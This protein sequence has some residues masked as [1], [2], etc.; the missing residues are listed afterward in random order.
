MSRLLNKKKCTVCKI[1][2]PLNDFHNRKVA[3]DGKRSDC[4]ECS[5][6]ASLKYNKTN[7]DKISANNKKWRVIHKTKLKFMRLKY[8]F[9]ITQEEYQ[10][11]LIKQNDSCAICQIPQKKLN[12]FLN[13]DHCHK[14]NKI[15][16]LL[17]EKC[18][19]GIGLFNDSIKLLT[20]TIN[21]LESNINE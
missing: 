17:C 8:K 20:K 10:N 1:I 13:V 15:R 5:I 3:S 2:K 7:P 19:M 6:K 11:F 14:T 12:R 18:N 4:K 21:Y 16:G 9:G